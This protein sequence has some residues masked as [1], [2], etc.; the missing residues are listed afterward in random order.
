MASTSAKRM[1]RHRERKAKGIVLTPRYEVK[2]HGIKLLAENGWLAA[3]ASIDPKSVSD[4]LLRFINETLKAS[5]KPL[6][7]PEKTKQQ[8]F[9]DAVRTMRSWLL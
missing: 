4:A 7:P 1:K 8:R 9:K 3:D 6:H 5:Q 2:P